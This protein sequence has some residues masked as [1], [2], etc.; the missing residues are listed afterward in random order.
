MKLS[1]PSPGTAI[2]NDKHISVVHTSVLRPS[3]SFDQ[4]LREP[5]LVDAPLGISL[6]IT[7]MRGPAPASLIFSPNDSAIVPG[8]AASTSR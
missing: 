5:A 6:E 1:V 3:Q 7:E 8:T 2:T 4:D